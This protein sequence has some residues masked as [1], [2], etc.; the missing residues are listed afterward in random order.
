[1]PRLLTRPK[2]K[3]AGLLRRTADRLAPPPAGDCGSG[4][5]WINYA[6]EPQFMSV[7]SVTGDLRRDY[8]F[9]AGGEWSYP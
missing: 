1:M 4:A 3:L 6:T 2:V 8:R 5:T 7:V 9:E